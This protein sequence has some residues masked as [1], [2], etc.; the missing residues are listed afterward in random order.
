[1][2]ALYEFGDRIAMA[3]LEPI[4][5][6][7]ALA[8]F[9]LF[10]WGVVEYLRAGATGGDGKEKGRQHMVWGIIGLAIVF[11]ANGIVSLLDATTNSILP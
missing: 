8:A 1:M 4:V 2:E 10:L 9:L 3:I 7:V 5:T 11:G 6:L